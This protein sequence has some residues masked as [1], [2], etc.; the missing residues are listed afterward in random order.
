ME[1]TGRERRLRRLWGPTSG[2]TVLMPI[3]QPVT[4]GPIAGLDAIDSQLGRLLAGAP[5]GII[6]HRGVLRRV[7]A[8]AARSTGVVMHLSAGT[9]LSGRGH[10]KKLTGDVVEAV[11]TGADAV[12]AQVTFGVP[13][14]TDMLHDL[15]QLAGACAQ[16]GMPLL[17]MVYVAGVDPAAAPEKIA[18][19][20]R[21][22]AELGSDIVKVPYTGSADSFATVVDGCFAP[23]VMAGGE[24]S[25]SW[26]DVL[27]DVKDALS[28]GAAGVCIGRKVQQHAAPERAL[29]DLHALV[30]A[31]NPG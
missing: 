17:A 6:G 9:A 20:A 7:P 5:N 2:R 30:H 14:E 3:D 8:E 13:E 22:A 19:A 26:E 21:A 15:A 1:S 27:L 11:R 16:W 31:N 12:S 24:P 29:A 25:D 18:H 28:A 4:M 10:V 23:V